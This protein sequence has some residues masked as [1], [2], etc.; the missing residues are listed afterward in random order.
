MCGRY[1]LATSRQQLADLFRLAGGPELPRRYNIAP[2]QPVPVV[3][4]AGDG[5]ALALARWGLIPHWS[6]VSVKRPSCV[7]AAERGRT[8]D[9]V[10]RLLW[11]DPR[12]INKVGLIKRLA[13]RSRGQ[14]F[15]SKA[16]PLACGRRLATLPP[17]S[18]RPG[19]ARLAQD[20][21]FG[22][23][24]EGPCFLLLLRPGTFCDVPQGG[25]SHRC[26]LRPAEAMLRHG[27]EGQVVRDGWARGGDLLQ[28]GQRLPV[29]SDAV[30]GGAEGG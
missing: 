12:A 23:A 5:R 16:A 6:K 11:R 4:P 14:A 30:L 27:H 25:H 19:A 22:L 9:A 29:L 26:L 20:K 21:L 13:R 28:G 18:S 1:S 15:G 17:A 10:R 8:A 24:Q 7:E 3:R 2:T